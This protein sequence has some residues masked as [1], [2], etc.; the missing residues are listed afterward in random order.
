MGLFNHK[1]K[2]G[3]GQ[4]YDLTKVSNNEVLKEEAAKKNNKLIQVFNF[5]NSIS[6]DNSLN[7]VELAQIL[8]FFQSLD[9]G[10]GKLSNKELEKGAEL[11][12]E[13]LNLDK[14]NKLKASDLKDFLK[15]IMETTQ[16]HSKDP[17]QT[18]LYNYEQQK[19]QIEHQNFLN[20]LDNDAQQA[21]LEPTNVEQIYKNPKT[22]LF[23]KYDPESKTF[24]YA[25]FN[26]E[27]NSYD[28]MTE[29]EI[30]Q[31]LKPEEKIED[32]EQK[33]EPVL[34]SYTVQNGETFTEIIKNSLKAQGIENP[35][36]EQIRQ[37][38]DKFKENN[39]NAV[40]T[41]ASGY[42]YLLVGAKVNLEG[43]LEDKNNAAQQQA[44][45]AEENP[46]LVWKPKDDGDD[47]VKRGFDAEG[48]KEA[49][50]KG[51][52][53]TV[54]TNYYL[55]A[56]SGKYYLYDPAKK[57]FRESKNTV[58]VASDGSFAKS[59]TN[60]DGSKKYILYNNDGYPT[61]MTAQKKDSTEL[62]TDMK[63]AAKSLGL[64]D[65]F[66]TDS[67]GIYYDP[68]TK[69]HF[70]WAAESST[71]NALDKDVRMVGVD[72]TEFDKDG[73][74]GSFQLKK[75]GTD[76]FTDDDGSTETCTYDP[77]T[78]KFKK[79]VKKDANGN[80]TKTIDYTRDSDGKIIL[81]L[82]TYSDKSSS[83]FSGYDENGKSTKR[84]NKDKD[85]NIESIYH[86]TN[87]K[88]GS[89]ISQQVDKDG[90]PIGEPT[91]YDDNGEETDKQKYEELQK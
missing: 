4:K 54:K 18:V 11:L 58:Y 31:A 26:Q 9:D 14:K 8:H 39:P 77:K 87:G 25:K 48:L 82:E 57:E 73:K 20:E 65:T 52:T 6:Q 41:T 27:T 30:S 76:V 1:I 86:F 29:E 62:Y 19:K 53:A 51:Y 2:I 24:K 72:G 16:K 88:D 91:Y 71:F 43:K 5:F 80:V 60:S 64:R 69:V 75:N 59:I 84:V 42:E 67:R 36:E 61:S 35:T 90:K 56:E 55:D 79:I 28:F 13:K 17:V 21:G 34:H 49:K 3:E 37:A 89:Y 44:A 81:Q 70:L 68:Q 74:S 85:G 50:A 12:N 83:E 32:Q 40:K 46:D 45:W 66:A 10:D 33:Q 47:P 63:E 78:G 23:V 15:N 7:S 38:K 22:N